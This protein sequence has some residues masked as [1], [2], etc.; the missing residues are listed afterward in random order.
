[1]V[2]RQSRVI[3]KIFKIFTKKNGVQFVNL[4]GLEFRFKR[5]KMDATDEYIYLWECI[6]KPP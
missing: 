2:R 5:N 3:R 4:D 1:M 6:K